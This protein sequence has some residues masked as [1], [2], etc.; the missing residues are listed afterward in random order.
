M[1]YLEKLKSKKSYVEVYMENKDAKKSYEKDERL[2]K[3][4]PDKLGNSYSVIRFLPRNMEEFDE[5]NS[6]LGPVYSHSFKNPTTEK[7]FI[8]NCPRSIDKDAKCPVCEYNWAIFKNYDKETA[9]EKTT[10]T[11]GKASYYANIIVLKDGTN[12]EN[13]GKIFI[14][15]FGKT[16]MDKIKNCLA[17]QYEEDPAFDPFH[18]IEGANFILK[19]K[20]KGGYLNFDDSK[21]ESQTPISKDNKKI[22]GVLEQLYSLND[23]IAP[24]N[25]KTYDA[26][27]T[28]FE[29]VMNS[30]IS[31]ETQKHFESNVTDDILNETEDEI[32]NSTKSSSTEDDDDILQAFLDKDDSNELPF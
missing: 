6:F 28:R 22:E 30:R 15:K 10:L 2:W 3:P 8:E 5:V 24:S 26:L 4:T 19:T 14:Y 32:L 13:N 23:I 25:F 17:P 29:F 21:F 11:K 16:I 12:P 7:W 27:K 9:K 31:P 1:S 20:K 18:P